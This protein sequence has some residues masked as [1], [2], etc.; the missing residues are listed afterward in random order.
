MRLGRRPLL[1]GAVAAGFVSPARAADID[2][3]I[4]SVPGEYAAL[5]AH[6]ALTAGLH[7]LLFS[8]GVSVEEEVELKE[9]AAGLGRLVMGPGAGTSVLAGVGL[10]FAN[11]LTASSATSVGV[12]AAAGKLGAELRG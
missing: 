6:H 1:S 7:V 10:G 5:E 9:R 11:V 2:V 4:V 12:V 8:D 3:A